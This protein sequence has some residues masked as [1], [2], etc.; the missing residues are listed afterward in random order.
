MFENRVVRRIFGLKRNKI[1]GGW[2]KIHDEKLHNLHP[3]TNISRRLK[4]RWM[5]LA[6]HAAFRGEKRNA[7]RELRQ[8]Q[9]ERDH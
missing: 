5:R 9:K 6:G 2:R 7:Y 3:S 8:S 4:Y 1:I